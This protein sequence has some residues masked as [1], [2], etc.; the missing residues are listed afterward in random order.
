MLGLVVLRRVD[1][2]ERVGTCD[3]HFG[4]LKGWC[5]GPHDGIFMR[6]VGW[7]MLAMQ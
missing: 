1:E 6:S 2:K 5:V 4:A 3:A 7:K